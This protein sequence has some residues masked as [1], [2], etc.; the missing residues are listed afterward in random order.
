MLELLD[1]APYEA[2]FV[3]CTPEGITLLHET[4]CEV[5]GNSQHFL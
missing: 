5:C 1:S 4:P 2:G 3:I